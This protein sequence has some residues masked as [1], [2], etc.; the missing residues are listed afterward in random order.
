MRRTGWGISA[1]YHLLLLVAFLSIH[2]RVPATPPQYVPISLIELPD[3]IQQ[4]EVRPDQLQ[5]VSLSTEVEREEYRE[6]VSLPPRSE[7][8]SE[9]GVRE[10][11]NWVTG[12][13]DKEPLPIDL[14][15]RTREAVGP[16]RAAASISSF[17]VAGRALTAVDSMLFVQQRLVEIADSVL[18]EARKGAKGDR[19]AR[20]F[21]EPGTIQELRG[22]P[23][24]PVFAVVG[25][26]VSELTKLGKRAWNKLIGHDPDAIPEPDLDLTFRQVLAYAALDDRHSLS[27]FEW[28][29]R[30]H[31]DFEGG[32]GELQ[33]L[34]AELSDRGLIRLILEDQVFCYR[35][36]V[37]LRD[38][39]N[40]Y[41]SFLNR[42]SKN[43][44]ERREQLIRII[45][46]LV[47]E[48]H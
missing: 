16:L 5:E 28:H 15:R 1:L 40:Y 25:V 4:V 2:L 3:E 24:I 35:R 37:P 31:P 36:N 22:E 30:L 42:L 8:R 46:A 14:T 7:V 48:P 45:A 9:V 47:R 32:L 26:V 20:P 11:V 17:D 19:M 34:A 41:T 38:V 6:D 12:P 39:V 33:Q 23:Q 10:G 18:E 29:S 27:I 13:P 44:V 21:P 43:D